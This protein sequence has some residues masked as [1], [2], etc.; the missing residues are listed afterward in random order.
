MLCMIIMSEYEM[1]LNENRIRVTECELLLLFDPA[2]FTSD[3]ARFQ[4][5]T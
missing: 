4:Q 2:H 3:A 1:K 5:D